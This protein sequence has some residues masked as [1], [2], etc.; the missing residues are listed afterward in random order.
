MRALVTMALLTSVLVTGPARAERVALLPLE[1]SGLL[2]KTRDDIDDTVRDELAARG[3][4]VKDKRATEAQIAEGQAA[5]LN[6]P[7]LTDACAR[8]VGLIAEVDTV[9]RARVELVADRMMLQLTRLQVDDDSAAARRALG[10]LTLPA[11]DD[12]NSIRTLVQRLLTGTGDVGPLPFS[13]DVKP[14]DAAL[15]IDGAAARAGVVW[16]PVGAHTVVASAPTFVTQT[17]AFEVRADGERNAL[18]L[19]L[20]VTPSDAPVMRYLGFG[21]LGVGV[22][23][24]LVSGVG[25]GAVEALLSQPFEPTQRQ[26]LQSFGFWALVGAAVGISAAAVGGAVAVVAP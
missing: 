13:V 19:A 14:S 11:L 9:F 21:G 15:A 22:T 2:S 16:L 5:G 20:A 12:G 6:C 25:A 4:T 7:T 1:G 17:Q 10:A 24:A 23:A 26:L 3:L 8:R 18:S